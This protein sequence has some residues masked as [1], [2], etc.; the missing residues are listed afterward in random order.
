MQKQRGERERRVAVCGSRCMCAFV[1]TWVC[2]T[3]E[4]GGGR[5]TAKRRKRATK[6]DRDREREK[7]REKQKAA[8]IDAP[9]NRR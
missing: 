5:E 1:G 8:L 7:E 9:G 2:F 4:R 6:R 3:C